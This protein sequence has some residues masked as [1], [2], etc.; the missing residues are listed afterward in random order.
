MALQYFL[1]KNLD[2]EIFNL[3]DATAHH[4]V[5]VVR[6]KVGEQLM[7]TDGNGKLCK[8]TIIEINKKYCTVKIIEEKIIKNQQ[9]NKLHIAVAFTKTAA[10]MEWLLEKATEI[11]IESITPLLTQRSE[12]TFFK[13][14][15][16]ENILQSAMLQSQQVFLPILHPPTTLI[17]LAKGCK[18][19]LKCIAHCIKNDEKKLLQNMLQKNTETIILIGPE[20]DFTEQ[21]VELC[22]QNNF[23]PISLGKTRLR[24]ETAGLVACVAFNLTQ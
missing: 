9:K 10:R 15:R 4:C 5:H 17:D 1:E 13:K 18:L 3:N 24:T 6:M 20:G 7:L 14:E 11:G 8:A 23:I 16:F 19:P 21:E 12:K 2:S 22:L